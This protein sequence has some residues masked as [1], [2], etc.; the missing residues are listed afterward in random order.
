MPTS[1][2]VSTGK[3]KLGGAVFRAPLGTA[4]P[5]DATTTL[6]A[7]FKELGYCSEDGVT[8]ENSAE[9]ETVKAWGGDPVLYTQ[10]EK[11][12]VWHFKLIE[13]MNIDALKTVYGDDNVTGTLE[14]GITI[15]A[16]SE[17]QGDYAWVIDMV[18]KGGI[19][20]RVVL[21]VAGVTSVGEIVYK[22]DEAVGYDTSIG[23]KP[24]AAGN[25]HYEYIVQP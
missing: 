15:K 2:K 5:T 14:T 18:L 3:P 11:Q 16:N 10:T 8:N 13:C 7:A 20:K 21:P 4:L 25:S 24:D 12:D 22:D 19:L 17:Q 9:T 1:T 23:A 6:N